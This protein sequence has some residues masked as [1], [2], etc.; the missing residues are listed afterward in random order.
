MVYTFAKKMRLPVFMLVSIVLWPT[1]S[2]RKAD[3]NSS[4]GPTLDRD[5]PRDVAVAKLDKI[6]FPLV[7]F[8]NTTLEDAVTWISQR[9][10]ELNPDV[11]D[12]FASGAY[13]NRQAWLA[14]HEDVGFDAAAD[15]D[16]DTGKDKQFSDIS[17]VSKDI[18]MLDLVAEIAERAKADAFLTSKGIIITPEYSDPTGGRSDIEIWKVLRKASADS[19]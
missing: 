3:F 9:G 15:S 6:V 7:R 19:H 8:E 5:R 2:C 4:G 17:Y 1:I 16:L 18:R 12:E 10:R 11:F 13:L 14:S